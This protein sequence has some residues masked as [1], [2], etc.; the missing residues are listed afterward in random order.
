MKEEQK[1]SKGI[2]NCSVYV[3]SL[4]DGWMIMDGLIIKQSPC[5]AKGMKNVIQWKSWP[6]PDEF[7]IDLKKNRNA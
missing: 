4:F 5:E 3:K 2:N 1:I 7:V 6:L